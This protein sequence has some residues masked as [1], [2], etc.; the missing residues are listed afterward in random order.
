MSTNLFIFFVATFISITILAA[1]M[2]RHT[3]V[4]TTTLTASIAADDSTMSVHRTQG[5]PSSGVLIIDAETIC[6]SGTTSTTFTG[7]TRGCRDS[8][9]AEHG[10]IAGSV[11]RRV[12][13]QAPGLVNTLVGFDIASAFSDGG[14][15]GLAK[16]VYTSA[17]NLPNFL[18][19]IAKMV[20]W[21]YSFLD[22]PYVYFKLIIML[23]LSAGMVLSFIRMALGR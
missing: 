4:A 20:M 22:G 17:K 1:I 11:N 6:Y 12:Y 10:L 18:Q 15:V 14:I 23:P 9:A 13:S 21:D 3:G 2:D 7:L 8:S 16:G 5:F 19:A